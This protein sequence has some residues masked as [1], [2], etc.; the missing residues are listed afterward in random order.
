MKKLKLFIIA[1]TLLVGCADK[2]DEEVVSQAPFSYFNTEAGVD[3]LINGVY[4]SLR[5]QFNGEQSFTLWNYGVDEYIQ[6]A[7]GSNKFVDTYT[8]QLN[9]SFGMFH[10]MWT[11]YYKGINNANIGLKLIPTVKA[12]GGALTSAGVKEQR[13]AEL[14]FLRGY[15]YFM[16]V[17]QFGPIPLNLEAIESLELEFPRAPVA[18]VY[19]AII[20][21]LRAAEAVLPGTQ[22]QRGRITSWAARHFLAKV[23]LTR[24]SAV[25]DQ[26]GQK[27]TDL[28]SAAY[29]ADMVINSGA[30]SL[31]PNF[32][33][34]WNIANEANPE[35]ILAAQFNNNA[36]LLNN[37]GNRVHL[38][39]QMTYDVK[40][41]M[42]RDITYGRPFRRIRPTSYTI[43]VFDRKND[44]RFYK[45]FRTAYFSND[46]TAP[47]TI[48]KWTQEEVDKGYVAASKLG[49][50]KFN[51]GD[52]AVFITMDQGISDAAIGKK[53]Y[54]W[55]PQNKWNNSDFPTLIKWMDP[56]RLDVGTEFAGRDGIMARL[57]ET[58]L[59]AAEAYGRKTDYVTA[60]A[61]INKLRERAAYKAG[62]VKPVHFYKSEGGTYGDVTSTEAAIT[63]PA[64]GSY[65]DTAPA[66]EQYPATATDKAS[67]FVHF[68]LNERTRE[69]LGELHRWNDLV[70]TETFYDRVKQFHSLAAPNVQPFHKLRPI[71]QAHLERVFTAGRPLTAEERAANQNQGY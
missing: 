34:L 60:A 43:N 22:S 13:M 61:R 50:N 37:S 21:D 7:D 26:R 25:T 41:G 5:W 68:I 58:Y 15:F 69:L 45:S 14:R 27:A 33:D 55:I 17:Q 2:L 52:T 12:E 38:Y 62:E 65:W 20:S 9:P 44:S 18:D 32:A 31:V 53:S 29:Y 51:V 59:I 67:R 23:Y 11:E 63:L 8:N 24:G 35:I 6:A 36:L 64:D 4:N 39:F 30:F 70:R 56:T 71:P 19:K 54:L 48:P 49:Q 16:L 42:E 10:D 40:P 28:D 57:A 47:F 3:A 66:L 1:A 46:R